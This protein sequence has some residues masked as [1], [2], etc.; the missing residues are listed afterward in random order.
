MKLASVLLM[1]AFALSSEASDIQVRK[2]AKAPQP[3]VEEFLL[4]ANYHSWVVLSPSSAGFPRTRH[5]KLVSKVYVEPSAY[6]QFGKMGE[7]PNKTIIVLEIRSTKPVKRGQCDI[8]GLEA[9]VKDNA[10]FPEP[11]IYYGIVY[12]PSVRNRKLLTRTCS[13]CDES[14]DI[15]LAMAFPTLRSV[16]NAKPHAVSPSIM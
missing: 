15:M 14:I 10:R 11:W 13:N 4:P 2:A 7:W 12:A 3:K 16:I 5:S 1:F 8:A 9:A 6:E